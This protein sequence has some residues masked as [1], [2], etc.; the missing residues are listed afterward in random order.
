MKVGYRGITF[1]KAWFNHFRATTTV[2]GEDHHKTHPNNRMQL[3][4]AFQ[5]DAARR[6]VLL[7]RC[8]ADAKT[9]FLH[10]IPEISDN[11]KIDLW[12]YVIQ[13]LIEPQ[14]ESRIVGLCSKI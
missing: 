13:F 6:R 10:S 3:A 2:V 1:R 9:S 14:L 7:L 11:L 4:W 5:N 8:S 12:F